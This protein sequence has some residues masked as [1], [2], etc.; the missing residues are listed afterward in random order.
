MRIYIQCILNRL[1]RRL[2]RSTHGSEQP[3]HGYMSANLGEL[4]AWRLRRKYLSSC[5]PISDK[6]D[7]VHSSFHLLSSTILPPPDRDVAARHGLWHNIN[8][9]ACGG[10]ALVRIFWRVLCRL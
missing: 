7:Q 5:R 4:E 9:G 6:K 1:F 8:A 10:R 2:V 3:V